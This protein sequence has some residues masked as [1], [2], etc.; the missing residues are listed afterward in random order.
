MVISER[1]HKMYTRAKREYML[2]LPRQRRATMQENHATVA[3]N[4]C[5]TVWDLVNNEY[6]KSGCGLEVSSS[7]DVLN[8]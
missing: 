7:P 4:T 5:K 6:R 3:P 8:N 2:G 1:Y